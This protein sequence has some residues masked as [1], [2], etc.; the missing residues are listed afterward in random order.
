VLVYFERYD[1]R[2]EAKR[3]IFEYIEPL[4]NCIRRHSSP[5]YRVPEAFEQANVA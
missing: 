3:A 4:Y 2:A 5:G 1:T